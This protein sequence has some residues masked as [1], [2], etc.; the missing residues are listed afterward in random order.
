MIQNQFRDAF[1]VL[2]GAAQQR[3][4]GGCPLE[5]QVGLMFPGESDTA[6][7]LDAVGSDP[8]ECR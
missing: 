5:I 7:N 6:V 1:S 3:R 8:A 4:V 2:F